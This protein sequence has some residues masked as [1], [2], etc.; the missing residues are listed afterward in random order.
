MVATQMPESMIKS[1]TPTRAEA[2]DVATAIFDGHDAVMLSA[3]SAAGAYPEEAVSMMSR[4]ICRTKQHSMRDQVS[5]ADPLS[6]SIL[7]EAVAG[8][9]TKLSKEIEDASIVAYSTAA[10]LRSA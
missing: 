4:I 10:L 2:F 8:A 9:S 6:R 7:G 1:P 5:L 3:E